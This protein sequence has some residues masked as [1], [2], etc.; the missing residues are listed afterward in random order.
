MKKKNHSKCKAWLVRNISDLI[1]PWQGRV[2]GREVSLVVTLSFSSLSPAC[3][4]EEIGLQN[5]ECTS[6]EW[7]DTTGV[8]RR[9]FMVRKSFTCSE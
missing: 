5:F 7:L 4:R 1:T 3:D 8:W 2:I 6:T 9:S